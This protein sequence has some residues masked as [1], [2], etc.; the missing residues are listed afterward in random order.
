[1][2]DRQRMAEVEAVVIEANVTD[3]ILSQAKVTDKALSF[4]ELM[5]QQGQQQA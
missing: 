4:E 5:E 2:S 1:M 3:F